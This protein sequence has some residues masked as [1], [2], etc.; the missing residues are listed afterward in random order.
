MRQE[1]RVKSIQFHI[2]NNILQNI[3]SS[4]KQYRHPSL[5]VSTSTIKCIIR[6][7]NWHSDIVT[8]CKKQWNSLSS[9]DD[10]VFGSS[11]LLP[12]YLGMKHQTCSSL[13]HVFERGFWW[14]LKN[15]QNSNVFHC[16]QWQ[17][18]IRSFWALDF[19]KP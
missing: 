7:W 13:K 14:K 19:S 1:T 3:I 11:S 6:W 17:V 2:F 15:W 8:A 9:V 16:K 12:V 10:L 4:G 5:T 18:K